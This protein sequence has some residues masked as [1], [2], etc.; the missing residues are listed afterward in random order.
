MTN[1]KISKIHKRVN[2]TAEERLM[3][4][5]SKLKA[6]VNTFWDEAE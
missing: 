3:E 4:K 5:A 1:G 2:S 6:P